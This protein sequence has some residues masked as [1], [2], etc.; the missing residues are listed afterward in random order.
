[1]RQVSI[2]VLSCMSV[3]AGCHDLALAKRANTSFTAGLTILP[4]QTGR[5]L[6][7]DHARSQ[8]RAADTYARGGTHFQAAKLP[9]ISTMKVGYE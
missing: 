5:A 8:A 6:G 4:R 9:A 3:F 1:M 2:I 7:S